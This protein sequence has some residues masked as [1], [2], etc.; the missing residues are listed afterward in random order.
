M[1][2]INDFHAPATNSAPM[3]RACTELA[4]VALPTH[5]P[6]PMQRYLITVQ[7][8]AR[9]FCTSPI[10]ELVTLSLLEMPGAQEVQVVRHTNLEAD[11]SFVASADH[12]AFMVERHLNHFGLTWTH[13]Q[14]LESSDPD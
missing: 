12:L 6:Y 1:K 9:R 14:L 10:E 13:L 8:T 11:A 4:S 5:L 2:G 3:S 7:R